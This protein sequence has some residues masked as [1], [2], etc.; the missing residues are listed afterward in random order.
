MAFK[1][2]EG[3]QKTWRRLD[4]QNLLPKLIANLKFKDGIE[5]ARLKPKPPPDPNARHQ[6]SA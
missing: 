4:G 1:L 2:I 6:N 5:A 3:A